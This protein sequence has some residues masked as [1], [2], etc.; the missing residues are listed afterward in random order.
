MMGVAV[1]AMLVIGMVGQS[2]SLPFWISSFGRGVGLQ[3]PLG[4]NLGGPYF[5]LLMAAMASTICFGLCVLAMC[6]TRH[7]PIKRYIGNYAMQGI[8]NAFNGIFVVYASPITRTPPVL[9]LVI[10]TS[11]ILFGM[12][13]TRLLTE[14]RPSYCAFKPILSISLLVASIAI[15][16]IGDTLS[17]DKI[18]RT[19]GQPI[20]FAIFWMIMALIGCFFG[21]FYNVLQER[22][23]AK[24]ATELA[25]SGVAE[26]VS[27][28]SR[29]STYNY[30]LS[31]FWSSVSLLIAFIACF[32]VDI[33]PVFG[34]STLDTL[35]TNT[36]N[37]FACFLGGAGCGY[38]NLM[39]G[40][41]FIGGYLITYVATII[42]NKE[43]A[44]YAIY[45]SSMGNPISIAVFI[46]TG[47]GTETTPLWAILPAV[48]L[49]TF[50][51]I[52]WKYWEHTTDAVD[53]T[54]SPVG[55][56]KLN[57]QSYG[58][59]DDASVA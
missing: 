3:A 4:E 39:Y 25:G 13:L 14:R 15:M 9:F 26:I 21:A 50:G 49:V 16:V 27:V 24:S 19:A 44:N 12:L 32:W 38:K 57:V 28:S 45:A 17:L 22:Y 23:L 35:L 8:A 53:A 1:T 54:P 29:E 18:T 6:G 46:A 11:G 37:S 7:V 59:V 42:L 20:G 40:S 56:R 30:F 52:L 48:A 43:S 36:R 33:L 41:M 31:L 55:Y 5:I 10:T 34:Y 58:S 51:T 47:F 2:V